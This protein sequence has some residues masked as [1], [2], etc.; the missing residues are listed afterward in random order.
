M[1]WVG[2]SEV[3]K[4]STV[5]FKDFVMVEGEKP[6]VHYSYAMQLSGLHINIWVVVTNYEICMYNSALMLV[7][8]KNS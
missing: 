3:H 4:F 1:T 7:W 2:I 8:F 5:S 6:P